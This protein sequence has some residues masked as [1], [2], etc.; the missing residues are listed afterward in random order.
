MLVMEKK[1]IKIKLKK[2]KELPNALNPN[3]IEEGF[4]RVFLM[5]KDMYEP[6]TLNERFYTSINWSTSA[7]QEI[8]DEKTFKTYSSIYEYEIIE[9]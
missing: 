9:D 7:V 3:N 8:I 2:L 1:Y 6:P 4:E 5:P